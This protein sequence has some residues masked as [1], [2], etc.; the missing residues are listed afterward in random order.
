[1]EKSSIKLKPQVLVIEDDRSVRRMLRFSLADS[2]FEVAE[3]DNGSAA[4]SRLESD[5]PDAVIVDLGLADGRGRAVL[6]W[7]HRR[8]LQENGRPVW[9]VVSA[10]DRDQATKQYGALGQHFL[11]KP[12]DPWDLVELLERLLQ[13]E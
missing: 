6:E 10:L 13:L 12:F 11:P 5:P 4:I 3:V 8:S 1:M 2:G 9:V 7:L